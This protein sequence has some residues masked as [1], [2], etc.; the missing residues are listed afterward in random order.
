MIEPIKFLI[1]DD[2]PANVVA[3]DALLRREGLEILKANS[4]A[5]AL[6]LLL[7]HDVALAILDVQMPEMDGFELAEFMRSSE[8]TKRVPI[9]FVTAGL[10]T[11]ERM[12]KGYESGAVDF[13]FKPV[14]PIILKSKA[15]VFFELFRQRRELTN[16]L[17]LNEM[18]VGI[19][20]HD[21]RNPLGALTTG[22]QVLERDASDDQRRVLQRM[23]SAGQR[24]TDMIEQMLDLTRARLAGGLG[25]LRARRTVDV[26]EV[27]TRAFDELRGVHANRDLRLEIIGE[28]TTSGDPGRLVQLFSN[29][30]ANAVQHGSPEAPVT[31]TAVGKEDVIE[32]RVHNSG[33]IHR[34]I[35]PG[36]FDPFRSRESGSRSG[37]LGLGLY[38]AQQIALAHEGDVAAESS[39]SSGTS[40]RVRLPRRP[41]ATKREPSASTK[42]VLIVDDDDDVRESIRD[43]LEREGYEVSK[44]ADGQ[45]AFDRLNDDGA[46]PDVVILD[47]VLPLVDGTRI[48]Q[49]MKADSRLANIPIVVSTAN[50]RRA[51]PGA[52]TVSKPVKLARLLDTIMQVSA[53]ATKS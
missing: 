28:C 31:I 45:Q 19:L 30:I 36:L 20:G 8:T 40:F 26:A 24:M 11:S 32:V 35:L 37:G 29:L 17:R 3:M 16:S 15:D 49:A 2:V 46:R 34:D 12:F 39:E 10:R 50:P 1:V 42:K 43:A 7:V 33:A 18:F 9:I 44:A 27:V 21:L 14:D 4:G 6:E 47:L 53:G 5:E 22:M 52:V 13:L 25:F 41:G 51:P 48:Y 38:I 23:S